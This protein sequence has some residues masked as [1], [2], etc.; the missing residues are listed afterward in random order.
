MAVL[1]SVLGS[2]SEVSPW[3]PAGCV[4]ETL[5]GGPSPR[6][7]TAGPAGAA[8]RPDRPARPRDEP[9]GGRA[10]ELAAERGVVAT[11]YEPGARPS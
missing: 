8:L 10:E 5:R 6:T 7:D 4:P 3:P 1:E 9:L 11:V 2:L